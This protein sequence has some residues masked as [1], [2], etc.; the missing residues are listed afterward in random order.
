MIANINEPTTK[1]VNRELLI[2]KR[3]QVD[4]KN[5]KCLQGWEKHESMFLTVHFCAKQISSIVGSQIEIERIFSLA[6]I[7]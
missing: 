2:F 6:R 5:V 7:L 4:V 3:Y 1:L